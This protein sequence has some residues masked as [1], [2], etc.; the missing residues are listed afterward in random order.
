MLSPY[1]GAARQTYE[2]I[3]TIGAYIP[4]HFYP[5]KDTYYYINQKGYMHILL[6]SALTFKGRKQFYVS[7]H[8]L[9]KDNMLKESGQRTRLYD[10][11]QAAIDAIL[12]V[13]KP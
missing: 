5:F 2:K 13:I 4:G 8:M 1:T 10:T 3:H 9:T 6:L 12:E 11:K 7:D